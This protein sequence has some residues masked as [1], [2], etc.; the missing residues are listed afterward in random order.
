MLKNRC[1][2]FQAHS[3]IDAGPW[4]GRQR[5]RRISL[6]LHEHEVPDLDVAIAIFIR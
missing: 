2:A 4:Q 6:I 3:G 5:A 1:K